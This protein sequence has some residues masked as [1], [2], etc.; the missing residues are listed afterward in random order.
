T[1][2]DDVYVS[3]IPFSKDVNIG[4]SNHAASYLDW[5]AWDSANTVTVNSNQFC[6]NGWTWNGWNLNYVGNCP[7]TTTAA[8]HNTWN[9]CVMDPG[10]ATPPGTSA[11]YDQKVDAP[12]AGNAATLFPPEQ[13]NSCPVQ[14]MGLSY[15]WSAMS[16]LVDSMVAD[17]TT[18][19]PIGL[20]W[21]WQSLV[22]GGPLVAP[23]KD[24][25]YVYQTII[26]LLS[27]GLNTADRWYGDGSHTSTQVDARMYDS[28]TT[29]GTCKNIKDSGV[30]IYTVQVNTNNDPTSTLLRNCASTT[31]KFFMLT[32][33]NQIVTTFNTIGTNIA[34][35]RLSN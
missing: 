23:A 19:Q 3:I 29:L 6:F 28:S 11:G 8:N 1:I 26:I 32:S 35:L 18:N 16:N 27:D 17:G 13:Y 33:A 22:G 14:M 31:D 24:P 20:V 4:K 10:T 21:G 30:V 5:S 25:N 15:N 12:V 7:S 2:P 34:K 9:G